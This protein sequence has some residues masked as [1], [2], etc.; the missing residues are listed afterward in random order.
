[1]TIQ[2]DTG[3]MEIGHDISEPHFE[4]TLLAIPGLALP[5]ITLHRIRE[6]ITLTMYTS[7]VYVALCLRCRRRLYT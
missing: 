6:S 7:H 5:T 4:F 1:M 2:Y 3:A